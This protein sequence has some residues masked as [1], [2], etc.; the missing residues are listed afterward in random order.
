MAGVSAP[1]LGLDV[2]SPVFHERDGAVR[3]RIDGKYE[4]LRSAS[5]NIGDPANSRPG[6]SRIKEAAE[7]RKVRDG[8]GCCSILKVRR[9]HNRYYVPARGPGRPYK[10]HLLGDGRLT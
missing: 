9:R 8:E 5:K 7:G 3:R 6:R 2:T 1:A 10:E 4:L